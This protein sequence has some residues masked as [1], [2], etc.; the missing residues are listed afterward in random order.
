M[1][2]NEVW[3]F[4]HQAA[5]DLEELARTIHWPI[6]HLNVINAYRGSKVRLYFPTVSELNHLFCTELGAFELHETY[7]PRTLWGIVVQL[8]YYNAADTM[9][10]R[11]R[12]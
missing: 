9:K 2:L 3:E 4:L 5:P 1:E 8:S 11:R 10:G 12:S 7:L 6:E